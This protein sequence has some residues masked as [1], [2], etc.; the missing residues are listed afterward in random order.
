MKNLGKFVVK[1]FKDWFEQVPAPLPTLCYVI[2]ICGW[3][4]SGFFTLGQDV[5]MKNAGVLA[6]F[7]ISLGGEEVTLV[8]MEPAGQNTWHTTNDDP[9]VH[10]QN[11]DGRAV[12]SLR[13]EAEFTKSPREMCVYYTTKAG[14]DFSQEKRVFAQ[15]QHD[16]S[17]LFSLPAGAI[18]ALRLDP[19][20][21]KNLDMTVTGIFLNEPVEFISYFNPG[22]Y[23]LSQMVI[24]PGVAAAALALLG[25][26]GRQV[27]EK[28]LK[29]PEA[30]PEKGNAPE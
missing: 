6:P 4:M 21:E 23:G 11:P 3:L 28:Y 5:A 12:R 7:T 26:G 15:P 9:Q 10:W 22:W 30:K 17:Y 24:W 25:R 8:N 19:C 16:G 29:D 1:W 2:C 20:S 14:E 18:T 13:M 27:Y